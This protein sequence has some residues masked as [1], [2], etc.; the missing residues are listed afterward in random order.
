[1]HVASSSVGLRSY[2]KDLAEVFADFWTRH[3][4]TPYLARSKLVASVCPQLHG[5]ALVKLAVLLTL[6]GSPSTTDQANGMRVRGEP[7]LLLVGDPGTGKS[8]FLRFAAKVSARSVLTTGVGTTSAGLTCSAVREGKEF[9][10][11]AGA[12]VL[13]DRGVCCIDEFAQM[14]EH[15]RA[16]IHEAMEQQSLSVA[17]AG[18][19]TRLN[20]RT[21]VVAACNAKGYYDADSDLS[22]NT[23]IASPL[24]SRFDL[25]VV[26]TDQPDVQWDKTVSEFILASR[27]DA[28]AVKRARAEAL[29]DGSAAAA[30]ARAPSLIAPELDVDKLRGYISHVKREEPELTAEASEVLRTF[31]TSQRRAEE[32]SES[33]RTTL[34]LLESLIRISKAHARL[35]NKPAVDVHDAV[36]AVGL[37]DL[38]LNPA[39]SLDAVHAD[40][41][42]DPDASMHKLVRDVLGR[43]RLGHLLPIV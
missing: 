15:D 13:A 8:Q 41:D 18:L 5:L 6:I 43:L 7:H 20:T 26:L 3:A 14:R 39:A 42:A 33:G 25:V 4:A 21:T 29:G 36:Q 40:F 24:L 28:T 12:L 9:M 2:A 27:A 23:G 11:E 38:S 31:F 22:T 37:V 1:V 34:R 19:V 32:A 35:M 30:A 10:L 16:T 17:K